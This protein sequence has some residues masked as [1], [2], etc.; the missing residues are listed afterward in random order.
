MMV[1]RGGRS[2]FVPRL[3]EGTDCSVQPAWVYGTIL[4]LPIVLS[5]S[6]SEG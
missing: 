4:L 6:S 2:P 3:A 5:R 1:G